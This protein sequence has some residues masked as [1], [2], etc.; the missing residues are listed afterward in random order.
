MGEA[1]GGEGSAARVAHG[2][3]VPSA[4]VLLGGRPKAKNLGGRRRPVGR[5][6]GGRAGAVRG[7]G[8]AGTACMY[9]KRIGDYE[10]TPTAQIAFVFW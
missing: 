8:G 10:G 2:P 1:G 5:R 7:T 3:F 9:P 4:R 6:V